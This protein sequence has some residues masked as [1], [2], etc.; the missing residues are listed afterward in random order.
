MAHAQAPQ[1]ARDRLALAP[2]SIAAKR[3]RTRAPRGVDLDVLA[4]L[5]V[6]QRQVPDGGKAPSRGSRDLD[7]EHRVAGAQRAERAR[8]VRPGS[9]KSEITTTRPGWRAIL[10][11]ARSASAE[12]RRSGVAV[13]AD[14]L[15]QRT[16]QRHEP[17]PDARGGSSRG[18]PR[19]EAYQRDA[20]GAA[21]RQAR[22]APARRPRRR[23]TSGAR[24]CR[25]PSTATRRARA[26]S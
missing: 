18:S 11:D 23:R 15:V 2:R 3:S 22:R 19:A 5:R 16:A 7:G 10:A 20:A 21:D 9:R 25:T 12:R 8:P 26:R 17:R 4:R 13:G 1:L 24:R 14:A 6:D